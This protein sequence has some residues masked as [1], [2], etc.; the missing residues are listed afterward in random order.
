MGTLET[1]IVF[2]VEAAKNAQFAWTLEGSQK[3]AGGKRSATPGNTQPE[4]PTLKG[5]HKTMEHFADRLTAAIRAKN[6]PVCVG[7]DPLLERL[8]KSF[9]RMAPS[10]DFEQYGS[11][12]I[13]AVADLV[14]SIKINI[15]F[16][17]PYGM[18]GIGAYQTLVGLARRAGLLV[19]G[20]VKRADIGHTSAQYAKATLEGESFDVADAATVN[21]YF[22][23]DGVGPF[24]EAAQKNSRGVFVL[25]QTSNESASQVQGL[26][27]QS[28]QTVC[29]HVA[30]LVQDWAAAPGRIGRSGYSCVGAVVSPRDI[31]STVKIRSLM[32]NCIFLVPGF[33]AQGRTADEV[34]K[35]FKPDGTG[36]IIA[37]SRSV[38][39]AYDE[40]KYKDRKD[41]WKGCIRDACIDFI[42][43]VRSV[44]Q[45]WRHANLSK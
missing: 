4:R 31:E 30:T 11:A 33:G 1:V 27:L 32:P 40:P 5:S 25:V 43:T 42:Q 17:E 34:A 45:P 14:P 10:K 12:V 19:I 41:D 15:A 22:G 7:L 24:V 36:A 37:A 21:P 28:G 44:A 23:W 16:F 6:A 20:D 29:Q 8:P 18:A 13:E 38:I 9:H 2:V 26:V 35:C 3:V 39:F